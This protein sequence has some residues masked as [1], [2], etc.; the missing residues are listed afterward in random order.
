MTH[1]QFVHAHQSGRLDVEIDKAAAMEL[2]ERRHIALRYA[3]WR[4]AAMWLWLLCPLAGVAMMLLGWWI[5]AI[6]VL[7]ACPVLREVILHASW[8]FVVRQAVADAQFYVQA[9]EAGAI[10]P[11]ARRP[12]AA[13]A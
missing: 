8:R 9:L 11:A 4:L 3:G 10:R 12:K 7:A 13:A 6:A 1:E 5:A 2:M